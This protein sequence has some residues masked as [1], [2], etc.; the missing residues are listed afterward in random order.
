MEPV[1]LVLGAIA[2][3]V[4]AA[5]AEAWMKRNKHKPLADKFSHSDRQ[6][7]ELGMEATKPAFFERFVRENTEIA[8]RNTART[9]NT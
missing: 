5:I 9:T 1:W 3:V 7:K 6:A 4:I 2:V 8:A